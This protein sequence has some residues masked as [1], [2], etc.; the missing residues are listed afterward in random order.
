MASQSP[1]EYFQE[2]IERAKKDPMYDIAVKV[3]AMRL[4]EKLEA[5]MANNG[6]GWNEIARAS[7]VRDAVEYWFETR[8]LLPKKASA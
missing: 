6:D 8:G 3:T 7:I 5:E 1:A 2:Q 4:S